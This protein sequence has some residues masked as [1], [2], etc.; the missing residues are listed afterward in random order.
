VSHQN[1][2]PTDGMMSNA[3]SFPPD[4]NEPEKPE[5][6]GL[7]PAMPD[8]DPADSA[9]G[10]GLSGVA[11]QA[12]SLARDQVSEG[13]GHAA[14]GVEHVA[15][16]ADQAGQNLRQN[17]QDALAQYASRAADRL[18]QFATHL[19]E[20]PPEQLLAETEQALKRQPA[21]ILAGSVA[22][23]LLAAR[24][25]KHTGSDTTKH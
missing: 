11:Q 7:V 17:D 23:G 24:V 22:L 4:A 14:D 8:V 25:F 18:E 21:L 10:S 3:Q 13:L 20:T 5:D 16:L 9:R 2:D 19:R 1:Y 15:N 6:T 12:A